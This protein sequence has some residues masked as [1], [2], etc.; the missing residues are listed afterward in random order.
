MSILLP[1]PIGSSFTLGSHWCVIVQQTDGWCDWQLH[2]HWQIYNWFDWLQMHA[3]KAWLEVYSKVYSASLHYSSTNKSIWVIGM[4]ETGRIL[5]SAQVGWKGS[6]EA[7]MGGLRKPRTNTIM[8]AER[9]EETLW[10]AW[11]RWRY[12]VDIII[13]IAERQSCDTWR[14][15]RSSF[16]PTSVGWTEAL[17][18]VRQSTNNQRIMDPVRDGHETQPQ[19][20]A[21]LTCD[22]MHGYLGAVNTPL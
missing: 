19:L 20:Q 4:H 22:V 8:A 16:I 2:G 11:T 15:Q 17:H 10:A 18:V 12:R 5:K 14:T 7:A 9:N 3:F 6:W 21:T 1:W 13:D